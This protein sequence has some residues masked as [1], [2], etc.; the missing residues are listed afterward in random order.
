MP[1]FENDYILNEL[2]ELRNQL[3]Y[4][5]QRFHNVD[6]LLKSNV[7]SIEN[8]LTLEHQ[9]GNKTDLS[10]KN[11]LDLQEKK[12]INETLA[13]QLKVLY[14]EFFNMQ[15]S[16]VWFSMQVAAFHALLQRASFYVAAERQTLAAKKDREER[17]AYEAKLR[18]EPNNPEEQLTG[19]EG[20]AQKARTFPFHLNPYNTWRY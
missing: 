7:E 1:S 4:A 14:Q 19:M 11:Q 2:K 13:Q 20:I 15:N 6:A 16:V 8:L 5:N 9:A 17:L 12:R 10:Y 3:E 18:K